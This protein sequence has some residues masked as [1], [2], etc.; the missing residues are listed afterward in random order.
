MADGT[1]KISRAR[2]KAGLG[3]PERSVTGIS[4]L[5]PWA[6]CLLRPG[7]SSETGMWLP[8]QPVRESES[9]Q[10]P[11]NP[12]TPPC[13]FEIGVGGEVG[14]RRLASGEP[15]P[16]LFG[17]RW[18]LKRDR[19]AGSWRAPRVGVSRAGW[20]GDLRSPGS[21]RPAGPKA[22]S[23]FG[24][25]HLDDSDARPVPTELEAFTVKE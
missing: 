10:G 2:E 21:G 17:R 14:A 23:A 13:H 15:A 3:P 6:L 20:A 11:T 24:V 8:V 4:F 16:I 18:F 25:T 22:Y 1:F 19:A 9:H 7:N 12:P 5:L